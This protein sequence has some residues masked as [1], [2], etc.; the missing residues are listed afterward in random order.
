MRNPLNARTS[1]G[2]RGPVLE[3]CNGLKGSGTRPPRAAWSTTSVGAPLDLSHR[4][5]DPRRRACDTGR[6]VRSLGLFLFITLPVAATAQ[7]LQVHVA[8][9]RLTVAAHDAS[10]KALVEAI[11]QETGLTLE[12]HESLNGQ[13]TVRFRRL[14]I[15]EGL[16]QILGDR[17]YMV[18]YA[19]E[20]A[21]DGGGTTRV[22]AR[23]RFFDR[24]VAD[25]P[26]VDRGAVSEVEHAAFFET[27]ETYSDP[28]DKQDTID[29]LVETGDPAVTRRLGRAALADPD[30]DVRSAAVE[31]LAI[32]GGPGAVEM[33]EIALHDRE[34]VIREEA[35]DALEQIGGEA[36]VRGLTVAL[37]DADTDLR[38]LAI[39]AVGALGGPAAILLLEYA[40]TD[41]DASV[42]DSAE[43]WL[44]ELSAEPR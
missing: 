28:W 25:A 21:P 18:V 40:A 9:G 37:Q 16:A 38:L 30:V 24:P 26:L 2:P 8:D 14:P 23:L 33:L 10:V 19:V 11:A 34:I 42:R 43:D 3:S 7:P 20:S 44:S 27:L 39:D 13:I 12:E 41:P 5:R 22:P 36:A 35:V 32:L 4:L 17:S 6:L 1:A 31:A 15:E 29:A